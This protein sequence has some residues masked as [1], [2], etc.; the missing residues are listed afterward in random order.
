MGAPEGAMPTEVMPLSSPVKSK[1]CETPSDA[2]RLPDSVS[3]CAAVREIVAASLS[4]C[5]A[6]DPSRDFG[7]IGMGGLRE[8]RA[9][10]QSELVTCE[11]RW[12]LISL[13]VMIE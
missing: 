13:G 6:K 3:F 8:Q 10:S 4:E 11:V 5:Q 7:G 9:E 12:T 1:A 2:D